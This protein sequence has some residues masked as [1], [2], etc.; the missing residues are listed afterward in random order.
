MSK[1]PLWKAGDGPSARVRPRDEDT[2]SPCRTHIPHPRSSTLRVQTDRVSSE[3]KEERGVEVVRG[4]VE[5]ITDIQQAAADIAFIKPGEIISCDGVFL[6]GHSV[7]FRRE[8]RYRQV[9][10]D[11]ESHLRRMHPRAREGRRARAYGLLPHPRK[12]GPRRLRQLRDYR[13][14]YK[15]ASIALS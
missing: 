12:Q 10:R 15:R 4:W 9:E 5:M 14:W 1:T 7:W 11:Q 6:N 3:K 13:G 8:W 2:Y